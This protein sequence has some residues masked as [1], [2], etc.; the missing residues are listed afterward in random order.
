[1]GNYHDLE[2]IRRLQ[3]V[4]GSD[5]AGILAPMLAGMTETIEEVE[6]GVA[7]G[8]L[9][10]AVRAAHSARNDA[11]VLGARPLLDALTELE[12]AGREYDSAGAGAALE[13][14][15]VVWPPTRAELEALTSK[16]RP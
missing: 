14:V 10:R 6:A 8:D 15:R 16:S 2:Q 3:E 1:M 11:L 13:R 12:A 9:D 5:A 4:M 7:A